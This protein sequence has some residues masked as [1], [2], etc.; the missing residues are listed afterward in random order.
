MHRHINIIIIIFITKH[1]DTIQHT[2]N[3]YDVKQLYTFRN[4]TAIVAINVM[5]VVKCERKVS[6][7]FHIDV[8]NL[9]LFHMAGRS[10]KYHSTYMCYRKR[11]NAVAITSGGMEPFIISSISI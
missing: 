10:I 8:R 6:T 4:I 5:T 2:N 1:H 9:F 3:S 7:I 11:Y